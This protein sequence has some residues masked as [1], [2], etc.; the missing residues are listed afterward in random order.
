MQNSGRKWQ[1]W[2]SYLSV[3][4]SQVLTVASLKRPSGLLYALLGFELHGHIVL[5]PTRSPAVGGRQWAAHGVCQLLGWWEQSAPLPP[6]S[7][8]AEAETGSCQTRSC[9]RATPEKRPHIII[10]QVVE[11]PNDAQP[12]RV[13]WWALGLWASRNAP[14]QWQVLLLTPIPAAQH[15]RCASYV[16]K[17]PTQVTN[18]N[19]LYRTSFHAQDPAGIPST[20][21]WNISDFNGDHPDKCQRIQTQKQIFPAIT[22][23]IQNQEASWQDTRPAWLCPFSGRNTYV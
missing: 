1:S 2:H 5:Q 10:F 12:S 18:P 20:F 7:L 21:Q 9:D 19:V 23:G 17:A 13:L 6:G 15:Q 8:R 3:L 4:V 11:P 14:G 16:F 22:R